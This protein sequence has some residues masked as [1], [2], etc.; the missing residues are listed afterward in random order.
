MNI[1]DLT[2]GFDMSQIMSDQLRGNF[3]PYHAMLNVPLV[4]GFLNLSC[5]V[6]YSRKI[7]DSR[8][9]YV[10]LDSGGNLYYVYEE[11]AEG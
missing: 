11:T 6:S 5:A 1:A 7:Y 2:K 4:S 9:F 8:V 3:V 10:F